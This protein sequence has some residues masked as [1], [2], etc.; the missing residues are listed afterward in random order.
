MR[1]A[2]SLQH[3]DIHV[4]FHRFD[5]SSMK[6]NCVVLIIAKRGSGKSMLVKDMMYNFRTIP[7]AVAVSATEE[8]TGFYQDVMPP[9][10]VRFEYS[11]DVLLK[12]MNRQKAVIHMK[13]RNPTID[14]RAMLVLDDCT[15]ETIGSRDPLLRKLF[16]NGRHSEL[17]LV[18]TLQYPLGIPPDM[19][20]QVSYTFILA[21]NS[22]HHRK[23]LWEKYAHVF[24]TFHLFCKIM[25]DLTSNYGC[26]V[27][28]N[29]HIGTLQDCVFWYRAGSNPPF[30][31]CARQLWQVDCQAGRDPAAK[32]AELQ[33]MKAQPRVFVEKLMR[34]NAMC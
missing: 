18:L 13:K 7:M 4:R 28:C 21:D 30:K 16:F 10:C 5:M 24:P 33:Q 15:T 9:V 20:G 8:L 19:R 17:L 32:A 11:Q 6:P 31:M 26:M 23:L 22:H 14:A 25:D 27:I 3:E 29:D 1:R 12:V 34:A 2:T